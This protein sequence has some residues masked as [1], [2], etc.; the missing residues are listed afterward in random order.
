MAK[1]RNTKPVEAAVNDP[2]P[3]VPADIAERMRPYLD[4][5]PKETVFF[6]TSDRQV[7]LS[8]AENDAINHQRSI[9]P[10]NPPYRFERE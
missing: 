7:F 1:A 6:I 4:A 9:Q 5:Y 10:E 2:A 3:P 8:A